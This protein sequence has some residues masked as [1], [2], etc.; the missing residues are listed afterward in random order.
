MNAGRDESV[1]TGVNLSTAEMNLSKPR[2]NAT[3][4]L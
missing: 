3:I 1:E 4:M 2:K